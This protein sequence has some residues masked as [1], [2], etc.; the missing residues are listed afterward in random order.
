[1]NPVVKLFLFL[2]FFPLM[3]GIF[4]IFILPLGMILLL[5][6][7]FMPSGRIFHIFSHPRGRNTS[8]R[9]GPGTEDAVYDVECT[10]VE[11]R[12]EPEK[13]KSSGTPP[14]LNP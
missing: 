9:P 4:L 14:E 11:S 3:A 8:S 2:L 7:L 12:P 6:S 13:E 1:M 10:V 5:L